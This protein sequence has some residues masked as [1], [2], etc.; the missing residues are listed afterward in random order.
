MRRIAVVLFC[1]LICKAV[2]AQVELG[3]IVKYGISFPYN[4]QPSELDI[5]GNV[6]QVAYEYHHLVYKFG[7]MSVSDE[8]YLV[9][10]YRPTLYKYNIAGNLISYE[11]YNGNSEWWILNYDNMGNEI[12]KNVDNQVA[13]YDYENGKLTRVSYINYRNYVARL[14]YTNGKLSKV[15]Q[16]NGDGAEYCTAFLNNGDVVK[17]VYHTQGWSITY[18]YNNHKLIS[19]N[20][21]TETI[22]YTYDDKGLVSREEHYK[23]GKFSKRSDYVY[24]YDSNGN[25]VVKMEVWTMQNGD[26][27]VSNS[28]RCGKVT[29]RKI[30]YRN[31]YGST[32]QNTGHQPTPSKIEQ[33]TVSSNK[34]N[35]DSTALLE[36]FKEYCKQGDWDKAYNPWTVLFKEYPECSQTLYSNGVAIVKKRMSLAASPPEIECWIDTLMMVYDQRIKY[37]AA[38][39]KLYDEGYILGRKGVDLLKYRKR[40]L[41]DAYNI[42]K[43]SIDLRG[44][45]TEAS[46]VQYAAQAS[47]AMYK[48]NQMN[49]SEFTSNYEQYTK[50]LPLIDCKDGDREQASKALSE[51]STLI[52]R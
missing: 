19:S 44:E 7:E 18:S 35:T 24:K 42:L 34:A 9:D 50:L 25:W 11:Y 17:K 36:S 21:G 13:K 33:N 28:Q 30:T 14:F 1:V 46:V 10:E 41:T 48:N 32:S 5:K 15:V 8:D 6:S 3:H 47:V 29:V 37:F 4:I 23:N 2:S 16:Y 51:M 40:S 45:K 22:K 43:K 27:K 31:D 52:N 49:L 26:L 12:G 38:K 20:D 39:S